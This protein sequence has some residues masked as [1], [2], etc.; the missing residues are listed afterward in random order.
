VSPE[1]SAAAATTSLRAARGTT[2]DGIRGV[3]D[4]DD[5]GKEEDEFSLPPTNARRAR[6]DIDAGVLE[7]D[8]RAGAE[9]REGRARR[10]IVSEKRANEEGLFSHY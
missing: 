8:F 5:D 9:T 1:A 4:D 10:C 3:G 7:E 2:D 6:G